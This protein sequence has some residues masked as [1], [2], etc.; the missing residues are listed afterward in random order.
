MSKYHS[1]WTKYGMRNNM[2]Q[3]RHIA[4]VIHTTLIGFNY[5]WP[6]V[7]IKWRRIMYV[8]WINCENIVFQ[9]FQN[10]WPLYLCS[11]NKDIISLFIWKIIKFLTSTEQIVIILKMLENYVFTINSFNI[12]NSASL[13]TYMWSRIIETY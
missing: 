8:K 10:Y 3:Q 6:H 7:C 11:P 4:F 5:S 12:H 1:K 9:H 13:Y 2:E